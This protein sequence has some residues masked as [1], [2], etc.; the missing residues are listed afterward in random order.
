MRYLIV[1]TSLLLFSCNPFI[2]K[3]KRIEKKANRKLERLVQKYPFLKV[4]DTLTETVSVTIPELKIDTFFVLNQDVSGVDSLLEVYAYK[5]D[6]LS[7]VEL[8]TTIKNYIINRPV[9]KDTVFIE[10]QGAT[11]KLWQNGD[12]LDFKLDIPERVVT[13]T[14]KIP[15]ERIVYKQN[16][17]SKLLDYFW[18]IFLTC[19][20]LFILFRFLFKN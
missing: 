10:H 19:V 17:L 16:F 5:L 7:K 18:V 13:K 3:Q 9:L 12:K 8:S 6:S 20:G 2:S 14:I 4:T 15:V 1:L 11:I